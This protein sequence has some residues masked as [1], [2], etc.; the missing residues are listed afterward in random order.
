MTAALWLPGML[1]LHA[2]LIATPAQ[3]GVELRVEAR[4]ITDDIESFVR[5]TDDATGDPVEGLT[6]DDFT[7]T[8]DGVT[9]SAS[10]F[11]S[12]PA[13][14]TQRVSIVFVMDYSNSVQDVA[15]DAVESA[16]T[17]FINAMTNGDMAAI[18]KFNR[19]SGVVLVREFTE[20]DQSTGTQALIDA[21]TLDHPG[22]GSPVL[23][24]INLATDHFV[25]SAS[26]LP[27]G[28]RAIIL[29]SDGGNNNSRATQS[30]VVANANDN[31]L[32][33]FTVGV[34]DIEQFGGLELL[35]SLA[36]DTGAAYLPAPSDAEIEEAY[37]TISELLNS[38]YL[39]TIPF[40]AITDCNSHTLEVAVTDQATSGSATFARCDTTPDPFSFADQTDVGRSV[41]LTSN[42]ETITGIDAPARITVAGGQYSIGC[43]DTFV[44]D[45][46]T[47]SENE[48]VCVRHTSSS[49]FSTTQN[50]TL[51][52]GGVSSTFTS[53]TAAEPP[54]AASG[55]GGGATGIATLFLGLAA[56]VFR[57]R[58]QSSVP[59]SIPAVPAI[60]SEA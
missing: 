58:R 13:Q 49:G 28:P 22:T 17:N 50:T 53:T 8:L 31:G 52:V 38:E 29:V 26:T 4:P 47:I 36:A 48:T 25:A 33:I 21:V 34:G 16:V 60:A 9:I 45:E 30:A 14:S 35:T 51:T 6:V 20:I 40:D 32:A 3:A 54:P 55:G 18:I 7:V 44:T 10:T 19:T 43:S 41:V 15:R 12:P 1:L 39:L 2:A 23:D 57:R 5:V 42:T 59:E 27:P 24:A 46:G 56:L 11:T 37:V